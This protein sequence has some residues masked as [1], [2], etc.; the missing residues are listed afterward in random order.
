MFSG[1]QMNIERQQATYR[2]QQASHRISQ[3]TIDALAEHIAVID[4]SGAIILVNKAWREFARS[5][6]ADPV[7]VSEGA[8]YLEVCDQAAAHHDRDACAAA[9]LIRGVAA[10]KH[11]TAMLEYPCH[12]QKEQRWFM[13]KVT[14]LP[15]DGPLR[16][17]IA[18]E[19]VSERKLAQDKIRLQDHLLAS[20]EQAV[21]ATDLSG[22]I[23][24]WNPFA[25]RLFGWASSEV[26]GRPVLDI[27]LEAY[28]KERVDILTRLTVGESWSGEFMVRHREG[29]TFPIHLTDS[30]IRDEKNR[31]IGIVGVSFDI[32]ER[33]KAEQALKLS[34]MVYQAIG[35]AIMVVNT[36]NRIIAI[37]PAFTQLTGYA[38]QE[39]VG[40]SA[41]LLK[42]GTQCPSFF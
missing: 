19:N 20:V 12:A 40:Q 36:E 42:T 38:E 6:G 16:I 41:D 27:G 30:L 21:I 39:I 1:T 13:L 34:D 22:A 10:G 29:R 4:S 15:T 24:Y 28:S 23:I 14:R 18:H 5:N 37:N 9:A 33:K 11:D 2:R 35:E 7:D 8:N 3:A 31:L 32:T 17:V 26:L 25:E